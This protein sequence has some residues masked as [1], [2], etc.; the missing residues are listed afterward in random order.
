M[1]I[2]DILKGRP[3]L[4]AV[5]VLACLLHSPP[6]SA[7]TV[8]INETTLVS[9]TDSSVEAFTIPTAGT[10][11]VQLSNIAWPQALSSL[12]FVASSA[13]NVLMAWQGAGTETFEVSAPGTYYAHVTGTAGGLLDLGLYSLT[14]SFRSAVAPVPLPSSQALLLWA[15]VMSLGLGWLQNRRGRDLLPAPAR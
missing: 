13:S 7:D 15:L 1:R 4:G 3:L 12:S 9:G 10:I 6:G 14:V 2:N 11:T 8:L 5:A